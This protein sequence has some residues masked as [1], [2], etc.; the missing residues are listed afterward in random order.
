[1]G[2][3]KQMNT[4]T[5]TVIPI[6]YL[7]ICFEKR[8]QIQGRRHCLDDNE[9]MVQLDLS[10]LLPSFLKISSTNHSLHFSAIKNKHYLFM[11]LLLFTLPGWHID[12]NILTAQ[13]SLPTPV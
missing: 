1:M 9:K 2:N 6:C 4:G 5:G 8:E 3:C 13:T 10:K 11:L 12:E 7:A